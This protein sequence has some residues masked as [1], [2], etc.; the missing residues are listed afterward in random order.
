MRHILGIDPDTK[1]V[2]IGVVSSEGES[3]WASYAHLLAVKNRKAPVRKRI[4]ELIHSTPETL[5]RLRMEVTELS[6]LDAIV[7]EGQ[8]HRP[9]TA[10]RAQDLIHLA[11]VA[12]IL[13]GTCREL[14][15]SAQI[16]FPEPAEW[17]GTIKKA[18]FTKRV[19]ENL[20][21]THSTST[22]L[23][24]VGGNLRVPGT[25]KITKADSSHV[26]DGLGLANWG[27]KKTRR[28]RAI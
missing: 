12:G 2:G 16:F 4:L 17:K 26:I 28:Y 9:H 22:G 6:C 3:S 1:T 18:V 15:P 5:K 25:T 11:Q 24:F 10:A 13:I 7:V 19:L 27:I 20:N 23:C 8:R 14:W 21:L